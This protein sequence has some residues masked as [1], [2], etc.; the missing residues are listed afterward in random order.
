MQ[1]TRPTLLVGFCLIWHPI[2]DR[3]K[4]DT[5]WSA[6]NTTLFTLCCSVPSAK[7]RCEL[8]LADTHSEGEC[9]QRGDQ[10]PELRDRMKAMEAAVLMMVKLAGG[11][12]DQT[13]RNR[14]ICRKFNSVRGCG[15]SKCKYWHACS[16][17][18]WVG[19][20]CP[21]PPAK[22]YFPWVRNVGAPPTLPRG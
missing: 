4:G 7:K 19:R 3:M 6:I 21:L 1:S 20:L 17:C 18:K 5:K 22:V 15:F 12:S 2:V 10:E 16:T 14:E 9:A 11:R 8:C 13:P